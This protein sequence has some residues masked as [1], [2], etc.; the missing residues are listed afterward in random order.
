VPAPP[1]SHPATLQI[2][3]SALY[4]FRAVSS[5]C[6]AFRWFVKSWVFNREGKNGNWVPAGRFDRSGNLR[7][8]TLAKQYQTQLAQFWV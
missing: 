4:L 7:P 3:Y 1:L 2:W 6:H 5:H 8:P